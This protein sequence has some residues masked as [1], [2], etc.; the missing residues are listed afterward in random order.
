MQVS[1]CKYKRIANL[2]FIFLSFINHAQNLLRETTLVVSDGD[3]VGLSSSLVRS[4]DVKNIFGIN[5]KSNFNLRDTT[6]CKMNA[7]Q[8][9]LA[10]QVVLR[11]SMLFVVQLNK[12]TRLVVRVSGEDFGLL[13]GTV[14]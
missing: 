6:R 4:T 2:T 13:V 3:E 14:E 10:K 12:Y 1:T 11:A 8:P 9:E 7:R 5:I